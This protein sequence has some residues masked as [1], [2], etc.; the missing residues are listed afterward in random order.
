MFKCTIYVPIL[1]IRFRPLFIFLG[2]FFQPVY[3]TFIIVILGMKKDKKKLIVL[4]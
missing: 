4:K 2:N 1:C 3:S